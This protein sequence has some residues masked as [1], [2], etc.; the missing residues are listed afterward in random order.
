MWLEVKGKKTREPSQ[1][2]RPSLWHINC[3][4]L[5]PHPTRPGLFTVTS[6]SFSYISEWLALKYNWIW[7]LDLTK[8]IYM[9]WTTRFII[10]LILIGSTKINQ[11]SSNWGALSM[12]FDAFNCKEKYL[13]N[14]KTKNKKLY[15]EEYLTWWGCVKWVEYLCENVCDI[16]GDFY[17]VSTKNSN[18]LRKIQLFWKNITLFNI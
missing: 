10:S 2:S 16:F 18:P 4:R 7:W 12:N 6:C 5:L 9:T 1:K 17:F 15:T 14:E 11:S 8:I 3:S 13:D